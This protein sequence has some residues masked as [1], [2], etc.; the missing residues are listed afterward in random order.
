VLPISAV[1]ELLAVTGFAI[2]LWMTLV[3]SPERQ[4]LPARFSG[5]A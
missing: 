4:A 3:V 2:N 1:A 5:S